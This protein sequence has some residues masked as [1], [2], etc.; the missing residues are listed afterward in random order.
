MHHV[1]YYSMKLSYLIR[2][3]V[4]FSLLLG[5]KA[6]STCTAFLQEN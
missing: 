3:D 4:L 2:E 6:E 1:F 5:L